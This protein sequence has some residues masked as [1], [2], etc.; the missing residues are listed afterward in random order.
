MFAFH[1]KSKNVPG[2]NLNNCFSWRLWFSTRSK[3]TFQFGLVEYNVLPF[4]VFSILILAHNTYRHNTLVT[5]LTNF[6][7][8]HYDKYCVC[9]ESETWH[10]IVLLLYHYRLGLNIFYCISIQSRWTWQHWDKGPLLTHYR[11]VN[12]HIGTLSLYT[13]YVYHLQSRKQA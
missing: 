6:R 2:A 5:I 8:N 4:N 11:L 7:Q 12:G 13:R 9:I 1:L 3:C 10:C